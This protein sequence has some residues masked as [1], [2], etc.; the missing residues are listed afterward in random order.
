MIKWLLII[1][2]NDAAQSKIGSVDF[3]FASDLNTL[4]SDKWV[5]FFKNTLQYGSAKPSKS[6]DGN[7]TASTK[8]TCKYD[9]VSFKVFGQ[10]KSSEKVA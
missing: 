7:P 1:L 2:N 6:V 9:I 3:F 10:R 4:F 8:R 5:T